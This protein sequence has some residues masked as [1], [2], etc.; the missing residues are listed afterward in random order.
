MTP[1]T[2]TP[3]VKLADART[4]TGRRGPI[5]AVVAGSLAVGLLAALLLVAAPFIP[6]EESQVI[7]AV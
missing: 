2:R 6:S 1:V 7:G 3:T 4:T 5:G